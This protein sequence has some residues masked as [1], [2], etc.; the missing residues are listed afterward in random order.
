MEN[1]YL[2]TDIAIYK[3]SGNEEA[4]YEIKETKEYID[5]EVP[6]YLMKPLNELKE[7]FSFKRRRP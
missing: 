3:I 6:K 7:Y 5:K 4:V 1:A 2:K